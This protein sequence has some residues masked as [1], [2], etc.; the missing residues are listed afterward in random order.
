MTDPAGLPFVTA[1]PDDVEAA[2]EQP[3]RA[4]VEHVMGMPVSFHVRGPLARDQSDGAGGAVGA[5]VRRGIADLHRTD[6]IFSTYR[7]D[8]QIS[9]LRRG[10]LTADHCD[11]WVREVIALCGEARERTGGWFDADLPDSAGVRRFDP[12]GLVKGW[13][14]E[15]VTREL[16]DAL[17]DHDVLVNA[18]GDLAVRCRRTDT[19]DWRLGIE[20]PFDRTQLLAT[21][22]LRSG[23]M[24]TSGTAARGAHILDPHTGRRLDRAGS[25]TVIGP[26]LLWVDVHATA[27]FAMGAEC[28]DYLAA[29]EGHL[30]F[31]V[32]PDGTTATITGT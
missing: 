22:P 26:D 6:E 29:L 2:P 5:A 28:V 25:I 14:I 7:A 18:G 13:A 4:W 11:P 24:A 23:G 8:S 31:V 3:R 10:E 15:R 17:A 16:A 21:V 1:A 30:S 9:R 27:A 32:H 12:T 19:P 20:D